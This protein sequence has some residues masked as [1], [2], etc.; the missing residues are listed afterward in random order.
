MARRYKRPPEDICVKES[1]RGGREKLE[2]SK[3]ADGSKYERSVCDL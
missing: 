1:A 3:S 2:R